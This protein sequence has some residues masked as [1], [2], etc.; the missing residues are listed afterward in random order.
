MSNDALNAVEAAGSDTEEFVFVAP[1]KTKKELVEGNLLEVISKVTTKDSLGNP[2]KLAC[3]VY[4]PF[5]FQNLAGFVGL[6]GE[7]P[8]MQALVYGLKIRAQNDMRR[9]L[10]TGDADSLADFPN[11]WTPDYKATGKEVDADAVVEFL[12]NQTEE[13]REALL[14]KILGPL[15]PAQKALLA[16][17]Q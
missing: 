15:T 5:G 16:G 4:M 9:F 3:R 2:K 8:V 6:Y 13:E 12:G 14:A 17:K 10:K 7:G 1:E 11:F